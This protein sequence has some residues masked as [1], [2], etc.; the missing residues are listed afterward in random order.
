VKISEP[1][2]GGGNQAIKSVVCI[3]LKKSKSRF[4][5]ARSKRQENRE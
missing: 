1:E 3:A 2:D 5:E 4:L